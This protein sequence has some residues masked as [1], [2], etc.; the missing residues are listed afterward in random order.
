MKAVYKCRD[1]FTLAGRNI[2]TCMFGKWTEASPVC[3][4]SE[5][6]SLSQGAN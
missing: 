3:Q 5:Y 6:R 1:G 4:E 2:T